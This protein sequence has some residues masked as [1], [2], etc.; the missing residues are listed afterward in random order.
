MPCSSLPYTRSHARLPFTT[1]TRCSLAL[2]VLLAAGLF[3]AQPSLAATDKASPSTAKEKPT[4]PPHASSRVIALRK[5]LAVC[6][7]KE[8][9]FSREAC[10]EK[11]RWKYCGAPFSRDLLWGKIPECPNAQ[12]Q[13]TTP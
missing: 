6:E 4:A 5:A 13:N 11:V 7:H 2:A 8:S 10:K 12:S 3:A 1:L 9:Y